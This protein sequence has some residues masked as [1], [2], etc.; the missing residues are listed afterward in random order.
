VWQESFPYQFW[1]FNEYAHM[2]YTQSTLQFQGNITYRSL[3]KCQF[4]DILGQ[5]VSSLILQRKGSILAYSFQVKCLSLIR[6]FFCNLPHSTHYL[7]WWWT[8][9]QWM[10][11]YSDLC[12]HPIIVCHNISKDKKKPSSFCIW[13]FIYDWT[14]ICITLIYSH[15]I[16]NHI[17]IRIIIVIYNSMH[18]AR[19]RSWPNHHFYHDL[20]RNIWFSVSKPTQV[21]LHELFL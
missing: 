20:V 17:P 10:I 1:V 15:L 19:T 11:I 18:V 4:Y 21:F 16:Y 13:F 7:T 2:F 14:F 9:V 12:T 8:I 3:D 6:Q 5:G